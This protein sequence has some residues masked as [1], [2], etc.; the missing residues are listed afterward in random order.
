MQQ[1][2][3]VEVWVRSNISRFENKFYNFCC[4]RGEH[5]VYKFQHSSQYMLISEMDNFVVFVSTFLNVDNALGD[6]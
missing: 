4:R 3:P 5:S 2:R 6:I 1:Y